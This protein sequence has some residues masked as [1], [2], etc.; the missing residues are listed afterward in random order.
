MVVGGSIGGAE[1]G[2]DG[3]VFLYES[4]NI[5]SWTYKS[6]ILVSGGKLGTMFECPDLFE[7]NGK[8]VL[9]CSPMN[10]P[11]MNKALYCVGQMDFEKGEYAI[12]KIGSLDVGFDYYAPQTFLDEHGN[13][14]MVAWQNGWL[15]MPWCE[16]WGPT[17]VENWRGT[18]SIPRVV[19]LNAEDEIC[20]YPIQ[21][22]ETMVRSREYLKNVEIT[23]EKHMLFPDTPKSFR[24]QIRL[25]VKK[26]R[27]RY[28]EVGVL[29]KG[30]H[31]TII[32]LDL[33]EGILSLDKNNG[34]LYGRGR[35]NRIICLNDDV[36]ELMIMVDCSSVEVYAEHGRYCITSNV[37]PEKDQTECWIRTPYKDAVI[38][39]IV[40]SSFDNM[41]E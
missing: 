4:E 15:W 8:W 23:S 24:I 40:I 28:L 33:L 31:A 14:V 36:V 21:E 25:D 35:M 27:S 6:E 41:W 17:S 1:T 13:R 29:G 30:E 5:F 11:L 26:I 34:D 37:Y 38:D 19:T 39:D 3:R 32:S 18:F 20:L 7:L 2:G 9:T 16:G 12:E 10:H 22:L